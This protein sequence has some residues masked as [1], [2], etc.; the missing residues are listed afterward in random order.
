MLHRLPDMFLEM[1]VSIGN[2]LLSLLQNHK[3]ISRYNG[4]VMSET[5][6][7]R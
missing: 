4:I 2:K 5:V 3:N 7:D 1:A 6:V